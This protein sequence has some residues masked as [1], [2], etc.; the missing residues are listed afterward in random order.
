MNLSCSIAYRMSQKYCNFPDRPCRP[1]TLLRGLMLIM[2]LTLGATGCIQ[3]QPSDSPSNKNAAPKLSLEGAGGADHCSLDFKTGKYDFKGNNHCT[4]DRAV[5]IEFE[6]APSASNVLLFDD[7][8]CDRNDDGN[9]F[10]IYLRI[11]KEDL[12]VAPIPLEEIMATPPGSVVR[13]GVRVMAHY[14]Y[15]SET[16]NKRTSC[17]QIQV[18]APE[19]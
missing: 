5:A 10:W 6:H 16:P 4:N 14:K 12:T 2:G 11:I 7:Y 15:Q 8:T 3:T 17:V 9:Y 19:F 1:K 18:D 13:P